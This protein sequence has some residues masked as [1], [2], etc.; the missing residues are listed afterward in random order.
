M[1][2]LI[3]TF[4]VYFCFKLRIKV[5]SEQLQPNFSIEFGSPIWDVR[6]NGRS[7]MVTER[8]EEAQQVLFSL[9]DLASHTFQ[10][11]QVSFEEE[12]WVSLVYLG[13]YVAV[14]QTFNDTQDIESQSIFAIDLQNQDALWQQA[15]CRFVNALPKTIKLLSGAEESFFVDLYSGDRID[16]PKALTSTNS[17]VTYPAYFEEHSDHFQTLK[18]FLGKHV[19]EEPGGS[20][21]YYQ[22]DR[23]FVISGNF[24]GKTGY[25]NELFVFNTSG[26]LYLH[27]VLDDQLSGLA[28]GAFFIVDRQLIFVKRKKE[29]LAYSI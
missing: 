11:E 2:A 17:E 19:S 13:T 23:F 14:F 20:F 26:E 4:I 10:W 28:S 22:S 25:S 16:E 8:N 27:E 1:Y 24:K 7:I 5:L 21:E 9:F 29:L 15:E 18:K 6:S 12:W 3:P